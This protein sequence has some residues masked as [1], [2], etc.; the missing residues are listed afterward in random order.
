MDKDLA[1]KNL[2]L[3]K[4]VF[5]QYEVPFYLVYGTALG[6]YRDG[7]FLP[8]DNDIDLAVVKPIDLKTRKM[9]GFMLFDLGFHPADVA[10]NIYNRWEPVEMG[11]NGDDKTGIIVCHKD[12]I[13]FTIF[14]FYEEDCKKHGREYVCIPRLGALKLISTP[15][16]FYEKSEKV[17]FKGDEY[18][19]PSPIEE[20]FEFTYEDW[21]NPLKRDHGLT[22]F[23][24]HPEHTEIL[25]DVMDKNQVYHAVKKNEE[26]FGGS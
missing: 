1:I 6:A 2:K 11:Y 10:F 22:Y 5:D 15:T 14:F 16:R 18:L 3:V 9:I 8:N 25:R 13:E 26:V 24:M 7:E 12:K 20:Y 23:E 17:K 21:K 19:I 4:K